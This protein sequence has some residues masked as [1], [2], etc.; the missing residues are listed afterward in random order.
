MVI[1][2]LGLVGSGRTSIGHCLADE[3]SYEF[4]EM[5]EAVMKKCGAKTFEEAYDGHLT[6]WKE[7]EL[8]ASREISL[9][10]NLVIAASNTWIDNDLNLH[11]FKENALELQVVYLRTKPEVLTQRLSSLN[12]SLKNDSGKRIIEKIKEIHRWRD[13][14]FSDYSDFAI[15]TD[16]LMPEE[17]SKMILKKIGNK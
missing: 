3:L 11:Y 14:L 8:E 17:A 15:D 6:N 7:K 10:D 13:V 5:E 4:V 16:D 9:K 2:L 1:L 12:K